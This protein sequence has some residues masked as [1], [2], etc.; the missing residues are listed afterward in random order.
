MTFEILCVYRKEGKQLYVDILRDGKIFNHL[1]VSSVI[2]YIINNSQ[3][4][5]VNFSIVSKSYF[6]GKNCSLKMEDLK[7]ERSRNISRD[8]EKPRFNNGGNVREGST[9]VTS[10]EQSNRS[11]EDSS[12]NVKG[13]QNNRERCSSNR[14]N[15]SKRTLIEDVVCLDKCSPKV[16]HNKFVEA[17]NCNKFSACVDIHTEEELQDM[18]CLYSDGNGFVAVCTDGNIVS[19][20]KASNS[21]K[22]GFTKTA[23]LNALSHNGDKLDCYMIG[24]TGLADMYMKAGF[25][26]ACVVKFNRDYAPDDWNYDLFSE[27]DIIFMYHNLDT[28]NEVNKK[29]GTYTNYIDY[30]KVNKLPVFDDYDD[31]YK[32]RD[33]L[34]RKKRSEKYK[35]SLRGIFNTVNSAFSKSK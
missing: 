32:Y 4:I 17:H 29:Y 2:S 34:L 6:K 26:P 22:S 3:S 10:K 30:C 12:N 1:D 18:L 24:G 35:K 8:N 20:L 28:I 9:R 27:P 15:N 19:V 14:G 33:N 16:F 21:S 13:S 5:C 31:A 7:D 11:R 25:I 23:L